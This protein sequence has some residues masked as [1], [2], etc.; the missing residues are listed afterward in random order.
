MR[1]V[2]ARAAAIGIGGRFDYDPGFVECVLRK[3]RRG[4]D[5]WGRESD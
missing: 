3:R 4:F 2:A 1:L 5:Q